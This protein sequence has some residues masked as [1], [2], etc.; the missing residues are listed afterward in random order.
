MLTVFGKNIPM[1]L[2]EL[3]LRKSALI[4]WDMQEGI[5]RR[6]VAVDDI[7]PNIRALAG[8]ARQRHLP[9]IYSQHF[10]LP[11]EAESDVFIRTQLRR[12]PSVDAS[13]L[14]PL[15]L[16]GTKACELLPEIAPLSGDIVLPKL[17]ASF[18]VDSPFRNV[19]ASAGVDVIVLTG[20][21]TNR[22]ILSTA[23]DAVNYYGIFPVVISDATS[24]FTKEDHALGL[25]QLRD[26]AD[27]CT[28][29]EVLAAW[30]S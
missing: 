13:S 29:R 19:L 16:P 26:I 18:F 10:S 21:A 28:T 15:S 24:A 6:A 11:L 23:A 20:V 8:A 5:A 3:F 17:R 2:S 12:L 30:S 7:T 1:S 27:V 14:T 25:T 22:G 4:V 9:V